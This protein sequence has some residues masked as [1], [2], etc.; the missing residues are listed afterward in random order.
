[1]FDLLCRADSVEDPRF[2]AVVFG[3]REAKQVLC[4]VLF[5]GGIDPKCFPEV[6]HSAFFVGFGVLSTLTIF[7]PRVLRTGA[8]LRAWFVLSF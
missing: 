5:T 4:N 3:L 2:S 6:V 7:S 8:D 1:M